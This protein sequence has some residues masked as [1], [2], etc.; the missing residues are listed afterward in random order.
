MALTI[1]SEA[2]MIDTLESDAMSSWLQENPVTGIYGKTVLFNSS[3]PYKIQ[4]TAL[5]SLALSL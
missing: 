4:R 3:V 1:P 5:S 2:R